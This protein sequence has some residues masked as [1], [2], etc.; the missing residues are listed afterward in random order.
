VRITIDIYVCIMCMNMY[1]TIFSFN[2]MGW[3]SKDETLF[4]SQF[5]F[6]E[7]SNNLDNGIQ[8]KFNFY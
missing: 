4:A 2:I 6:V 8:M 1:S 7:K 5:S 3:T